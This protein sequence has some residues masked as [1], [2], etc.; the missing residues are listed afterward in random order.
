MMKRHS[1][2]KVFLTSLL[3]EDDIAIFTGIDTC[4]EAYEYDRPGNFYLND[5]FGLALPLAVGISMGTRRKVFVFTGEGDFLRELAAGIQ[6]ASS[7]SNNLFMVVLNNGV[8]DSV[9]KLPNLFSG[10]RSTRSMMASFGVIMNDYT[11][12][13]KERTYKQIA[14][15]F[16]DLKGPLAIFVDVATGTKKNLKTVEIN[17]ETLVSRLIHFNSSPLP[18]EEV[19]KS[20]IPILEANKPVE[21][22]GSD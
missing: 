16:Y 19:D 5:N 6:M 8:Y 1:V 17:N 9:G 11:P 14:N 22:G 12:Y 18:E 3:E 13:F 15:F 10:M 4:K 7:L 21:F 20:K 2:L